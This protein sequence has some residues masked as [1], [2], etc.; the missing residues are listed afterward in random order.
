MSRIIKIDDEPVENRSPG[1]PN[2]Y[3]LE[4]KILDKTKVIVGLA[5]RAEPGTVTTMILGAR[6]LNPN[7]GKLG[8][9]T[10]WFENGSAPNHPVEVEIGPENVPFGVQGVIG[11]LG[12]RMHPGTI[13][14]MRL[15]TRKIQ[16]DG[17]LWPLE[18][19]NFGAPPP[20][21][22]EVEDILPHGYVLTSIKLRAEPGKFTH[23]RVHYSKLIKE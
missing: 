13:T 18:K 19:Y 7:N 5:L 22:Y 2:G 4:A 17:R 15:W 8:E 10:F 1:P 23:I 12:V 9:E 20:N 6:K 16:S 21:G 3:E 14:S 11:G